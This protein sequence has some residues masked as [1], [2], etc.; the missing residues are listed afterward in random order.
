MT[1][2]A[3]PAALHRWTA[4]VPYNY[5]STVTVLGVGS[6]VKSGSSFA[7]WN[8]AS[9]G[10]GA[11]YVAG[12]T[13]N[14]AANTTLYAQWTTTPTITVGGTLSAVSTTYGTASPSPTSFTVSGV[15]LTENLTVTPPSGFE[16][17]LSS[18][19][20]YT[21]SLPITA[22]GTL[23]STTV[24][25]RL[26]ATAVVSGSPYSGNITVSGG[27]ADSETI[28]TA[29]STVA[30][31]DLTITGLTG[32]DKPYDQTTTATLTGTPAYVGLE[33]GESFSVTGTPSASFA[34]ATAGGP[35]TITVTGYT[36]PSDNYTVTQPSLSGTITSLTLTIPDAAVTSRAFNGTSNATIT[37]TLTGVLSPDVVTYSGGGLFG[38]TNAGTGIAVT[39]NLALGGADAGNYILT[40]PTGL[41]GDITKA[42]QTITF[43]ALPAKTTTDSSFALTATASSGLA[44]S[45]ASSDEDV[46]TVSGS[47]VTIVGAGSTVITA[48]QLGDGNYNAALSSNRTLTVTA[49]P[50]A[51]WDLTGSNNVATATATAIDTHLASSPVL[52]RGAGASGSAGANSFRTVGFQNNGISTANTDYFQTSIKAVSGY[53][54]S[55]STIDAIFNGTQTY[56]GS[57]GVTNQ[58]AYSLNGTTFTLIG[59]PVIV[60]GTVPITSPQLDLT[61]ISAL[62]NVPASTTIYFRYYASGQTPTG[63]WGFSSPS[64]GSYGL[65]FGG[66]LDIV[67][68]PTITGTATADAFTTIYGTP[69]DSQDFPVSGANLTDDITAT[70]PTGFEVST[71]DSTYGPTATFT[72]SSGSASGTLYVRLK[73]NAAAGGNYNSKLIQL[74]STDADEVDI[75]TA[76]SGNSVTAKGV[77]VAS[78]LTAN[79]KV[80]DGNDTATISSNTVTLAGVISGE[81]SLV[82]V[83]TQRLQRELREREQSQRHQ[84]DS[85]RIDPRRFRRG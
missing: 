37:G 77:T 51:A 29:S 13:F 83:T 42:D 3:A 6:L 63:G 16:V 25:V 54:L 82:T 43:A 79:S 33:N 58:W 19:S 57:A 8:T 26:P 30:T 49:P 32:D 17:S 62:Q 85:E 34:T 2:I 72:E 64:A 61:G 14:I 12:N 22:S 7:S 50:I 68:P 81:E 67:T 28:A 56:V 78:G 20:G 74:T 80:Y 41:A 48:S 59:S 9:D 55:L 60:S 71:D 76:S 44:V 11:N 38:D 45:Y 75:T 15:N 23:A 40:Q 21:T 73:A 1:V 46:A 69:S 39:A 24:Y 52:S 84:R 4:A 47:T 18:G 27:G 10:S 53:T 5:N 70:A 31:K 35:K 36:P 66:T 65:A